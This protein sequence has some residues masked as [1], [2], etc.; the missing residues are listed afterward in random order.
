MSSCDDRQHVILA[1]LN[2]K[3]IHT[4][5]ALRYLKEHCRQAENCSIAI[6]EFTINQSTRAIMAELFL[7]QP[8]VLGFSCYIWNI[9]EI[10]AICDDY[11]RVSPET[12]IIL[13]GPEVSYDA[14]EILLSHPGVDF[15]VRGEGEDTLLQLLAA[16]PQKHGFEQI[17]GL[18]Y[19]VQDAIVHNPHRAW[20]P[21]LDRIPF[22]Y[23]DGL[24]MMTDQIIYYE[25]SRGCPFRCSY[26]LSAA[27][28]GIRNFSMARV[29]ADLEQLLSQPVREIKF[30]DRTI[31]L[32]EARFRAIMEFIISR[33]GS[34]QVHFEV[35]AALFS[36]LM[37]E[38]LEGVPKGLFNFE[39]GVQTT[40]EPALRAVRR[41][42]DWKRLSSNVKRLKAAG[43]IHLHLDL[44]AGLPGEDLTRFAESFNMVYE[45][46]PHYLQLGF[47]KL[48]KGSPLYRESDH[49][50]YICQ[51]QPPYQVLANHHLN[52][53]QIAHLEDIEEVLDKYYNS[54]NMPVTIDCL[55]KN[56]YH[57][58]PMDF[59]S[60]L[61]DFWRN[62]GWFG[63]GHRQESLY[64]YLL[65]FVR[66][67]HPQHQDLAVE[68]L[69][70]DY[71]CRHHTHGLPPGLASCNPGD[72]NDRIYRLASNQEF[73]D[74]YVPHVATLS[75]RDRKKLLHLEYFRFD[76]LGEND[77]D[78][79]AL[80]LFAYDPIRK[81]AHALVR[82]GEGLS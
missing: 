45:L 57:S 71:L 53:G 79:P 67:I 10:L 12:S 74:H 73:I 26:C 42:M 3:Y 36:D 58:R 5:L 46:Q 76:P 19:R 44:I 17:S 32:D 49:Y 65:E 38:F 61:A 6:K 7:A 34:S 8:E 24:G 28:P 75:P 55:I 33:Q 70:Y 66:R 50:G 18:S 51:S 25:S 15:I 77:Q 69:K 30:V 20:M 78:K 29:E 43:N 41:R 23:A 22:P 4:S 63:I 56:A 59:Y 11:K 68:K 60:D 81:I 62:N 27:Q 47:L 9:Q 16:L 39:V 54:G 80:I 1:T 35:D 40:Y 21:D 72:I 2:A 48:L 82:M 52:Y 64:L 13:G 31:N 37:L 14:D